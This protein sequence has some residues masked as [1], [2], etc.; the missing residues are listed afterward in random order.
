MIAA[1][2]AGHPATADAGA[3]IL[4]EGG[5]AADAAV[6]ACLASC[7]AETVMTGLLGGGHGI[8]FDAAS[9][10]TRLL[11]CFVSVPSG[12]GAPLDE[13]EVPFGEE[14]VHYA[15]GASSCAVPGVPAGLDTLWRAHGRLPWA[16]L[17]EPALQLARGGV[18]MPPA[19]ASCLAMLAPVMTMREGAA[20]Y[21][22]GGALLESGELLVQ[23]GLVPAL[24]LV[25]DEGAASVYRGSIAEALVTLVAQRDGVLL[26]SDLEAYEA[27][28]SGPSEVRFAGRRLATRAGLSGMPETLARFDPSGGDASLLAALDDGAGGAG[29]TTNVTVV[30][31]QGSACVL[32][33]SLG[34]GS[35]DFLPGLD[36]H[37]NSML[38]ETDLVREPLRP[39]ER[40]ASMMAPTVVFDDDGL[41]LALGAAGGTRLRTA[42]A[43]VLGRVLHDGVAPQ[44]AIDRPRFHPAGPLLNAEP[45]VDEAFLSAVEAGGRLVRRWPELHHYFGGV[46]AVGRAGAGADP[47]RSG[48]TR[49]V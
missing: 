38:G 25:R 33:T 45:G 22:P 42:L 20:I 23:P 32:T 40:M 34:L 1:V 39:G 5:S 37:L 18:V 6:A 4:A 11:D 26:R 49:T 46:S 48:A 21:A 47:R 12:V 16:R 9:G 29:H 13:L 10:A 44:D 8:Y 7:V 17:V 15:V 35:G 43:G 24:E 14:L 19:H 41:E 28:W 36:L 31:A 27:Q 2:A 3:E 30:D